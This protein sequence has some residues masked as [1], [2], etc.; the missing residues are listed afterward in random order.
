MD[1]YIGGLRSITRTPFRDA[2]VISAPEIPINQ[3]QENIATTIDPEQEHFAPHNN[4]RLEYAVEYRN[5][6]SY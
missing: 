3:I 5:C 6:S 4:V 2:V 1:L